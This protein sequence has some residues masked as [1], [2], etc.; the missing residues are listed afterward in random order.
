MNGYDYT[1]NH[2]GSIPG[3][4]GLNLFTKDMPIYNETR[5]SWNEQ[6][7]ILSDGSDELTPKGFV[8][9]VIDIGN[10]IYVDF[11]NLHA[12]AYGGEGSIAARTSQYKQLAEFIQARSAENDR[13][14]IVTGDFNTQGVVNKTLSYNTMIAGGFSDSSR[15]AKEGEAKTTFTD[16]NSE[17]SGIIFDYVFVSS[18]LKNSVETYTVCPAKR[19]GK[20]VSDHNAIVAKIVI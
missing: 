1:T 6:S 12:D 19:D 11:Y 18:E 3:G 8:Y 15:I 7:G 9:T 2:T 14:V 17:N 20:W 10:G 5:V 4:D 13:P 16:M